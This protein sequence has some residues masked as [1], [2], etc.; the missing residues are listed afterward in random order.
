M[1]KFFGHLY[2]IGRGNLLHTGAGFKLTSDDGKLDYEQKPLASYTLNSDFNWYEIGD[3]VSIGNHNAL[4]YCFPKIATDIVTK[5]RLA[6]EELFKK[7]SNE[8]HLKSKDCSIK[9]HC[10][11][12]CDK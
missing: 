2:H 7:L 10:D 9:E 8:L 11:K 6:A 12:K 1:K 3:V 4:F 5:A